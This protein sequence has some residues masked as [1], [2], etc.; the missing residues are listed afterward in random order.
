MSAKLRQNGDVQFFS[1]KICQT[2]FYSALLWN[3]K[4]TILTQELLRIFLNCSRGLPWKNVVDHANHMMLRLQFSG[5]N[6]R[7]R[8]EVVRSALAAYNRLVQLDASGEKPLY[9]PR[10]WRT[11]ERARAR[12]SKRETWFR[13]DG[14]ESVILY[15][16]RLVPS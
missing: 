8:E 2:E 11:N 9:R 10:E 4:R 13:G 6:K 3:C 1:K 16:Q 15:Q 14:C 5:Y 7:F 12:R